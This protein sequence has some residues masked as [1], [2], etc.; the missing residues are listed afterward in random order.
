MPLNIVVCIKQVPAPE[1]FS[2]ITLD[3]EKNTIIRGGIPSVINPLD[4]HALEEGLRIRERLSGRVTA[5]SMGPPQAREV[6]EEALAMGVDDAVLLCD[7]AL[8]GAD[9]LATAYSLARAIK[10]LGKFDIILCGNQTID[11]ATGQVGPQLAELL[12]I[13]HVTYANRIEF[14]DGSF[15][16]VRRVIEHGYLDVNLQLPALICVLREI[17]QFRL[18]TAIGIIE[19]ASKE[20]K[21]WNCGDIEADTEYVGLG[22]SPTRVVG[23]FKHKLE[24]RREILEGSP[25]EVAQKAVHRLRELGGI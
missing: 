4:R 16:V 9:T 10:K 8:A 7:R 2:K 12:D 5:L 13:P 25:Q 6:L 3:A 21:T 19:A 24:R 20:I 14:V 17:N 18:P 22:G 15:L 23:V 1:H 11:G